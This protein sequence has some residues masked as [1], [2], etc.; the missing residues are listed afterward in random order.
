MDVFLAATTH[1]GLLVL[2]A[3]VLNSTDEAA[4]R[5]AAVITNSSSKVSHGHRRIVVKV[6]EKCLWEQRRHQR[7][8]KAA[9]PPVWLAVRLGYLPLHSWMT[10][11][12]FEKEASGYLLAS[13]K[14][15]IPAGFAEVADTEAKTVFGRHCNHG[16]DPTGN[17]QS[18]GKGEPVGGDGE[19]TATPI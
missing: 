14:T 2:C 12:A 9:K 13:A 18:T 1:H 10:Q 7:P 5:P 17:D 4:L 19:D 16:R 3:I 11:E 15:T 6:D 8:E